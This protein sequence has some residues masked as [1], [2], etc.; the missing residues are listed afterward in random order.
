MRA[1]VSYPGV[2][3]YR[4]YAVREE[5]HGV[6]ELLHKRGLGV[7]DPA[8]Q[9]RPGA[10]VPVGNLESVLPLAPQ[11]PTRILRTASR[12][13]QL[14]IRLNY[15]RL[16]LLKSTEISENAAAPNAPLDF[17]WSRGLARRSEIRSGRS[18]RLSI[19]TTTLV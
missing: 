10:P 4:P 2:C 9:P 3:D 6:R 13:S 14:P 11:L 16:G 15:C 18:S 17:R 5:Q 1:I 8:L 19:A 12:R 7:D